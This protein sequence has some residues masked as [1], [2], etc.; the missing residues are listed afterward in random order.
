MGTLDAGAHHDGDGSPPGGLPLEFLRDAD[1]GT[2][3]PRA[4]GAGRAVADRVDGDGAGG[5]LAALQGEQMKRAKLRGLLRNVAVAPGNWGSPE[6]VP[7][8]VAALDDE[9]PLVRGHAAWA[10]G[11]IVAGPSAHSD[12]VYAIGAALH[13]RLLRSRIPRVRDELENAP[14][15]DGEAEGLPSVHLLCGVSTRWGVEA[16]ESAP[17][18]REAYGPLRDPRL[19]S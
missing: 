7:A 4:R 6:A 19:C 12:D 16:V 2:G 5:V 14:G 9:E 13:L 17:G 15:P 10:L 18:T 3:V 8:L 11:R 1:G